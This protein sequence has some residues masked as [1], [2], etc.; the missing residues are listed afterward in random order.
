MID[1]VEN[2]ICT[3]I[4]KARRGTLFFSDNFSSVGNAPAWIKEI[5]RYSLEKLKSNEQG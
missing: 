2:K 3:K 4:K 5:I 1:T